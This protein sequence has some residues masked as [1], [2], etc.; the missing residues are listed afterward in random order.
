[1]PAWKPYNQP[2]K[3][4]LTAAAALAAGAILLPG[5]T[6]GVLICFLLYRLVRD[7][8][9]QL[10]SP[11]PLRLALAGFFIRLPV[12][13]YLAI[14]SAFTGG[15][16]T[17]FG[18]SNLVFMVSYYA[19]QAFLGTF[20]PIQNSHLQPGFYGYSLVNWLFGALHY[21]FGYSPFLAMLANVLM[22]VLS[23][24][25]VFLITLR[26]TGR[27]E[28]A[29]LALGLTIFMPSQIL[30]SINLLK[31]PTITLSLTFILYLF[32]EMIARRHW[33]RLLPIVALCLPLGQ[34][35]PQTH[36]LALGTV[37][38]GCV[39]FIPRRVWP[40]VSILAAGG[41]A[42][43]VK[44]GPS[45]IEQ[46]IRQVQASIIGYQNGFIS[47][48]GSYYVAIPY[49]LSYLG[50]GGDGGPM[51]A[52][53]TVQTYVKS[54]YYYLAS[55]ILTR[56]LNLSKIVIAP[57]IILWLALL[58]FCFVPGALWL[59]RYRKR[60]S[61]ILL[62]FLAIFTS[63]MALFTGNEGAALRQ[64]DVLTPIFFI[65]IAVG[66]YNLTGWCSRRKR[67]RAKVLDLDS[68]SNNQP[69]PET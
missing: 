23:G 12:I 41:M 8:C 2:E 46:L 56:N 21:L 48:G 1:M 62:L 40:G 10:D 32:V 67:P 64:R 47:T 7:K 30:W 28:I 9:A 54:I 18:D 45:R 31:E 53:E 68:T 58:V 5:V 6:A 17:L 43:A 4:L 42:L 36:L 20:G 26:L 27:T 37:G 34:M 59:L 29:S 63:A 44:L 24:W 55:P 14:K 50:Q 25:L 57:Q 52:V 49:R 16:V 69:V 3:A 22:S 35:R 38:L 33:W 61:G 19:Q 65:P 13:L 66:Y 39:L 15:V 60:E 11:W 51:T